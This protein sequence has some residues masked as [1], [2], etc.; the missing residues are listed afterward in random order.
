MTQAEDHAVIGITAFTLA[1][2]VCGLAPSLEVLNI[3][4]AMQGVAAATVDV[5]SLAL[6]SEAFPDPKQ[7][8]RA[9][10]IWTAIANVGTALGS[11]LGGVLFEQFG[12]RASSSSTCRWAYR[13]S[14]FRCATSPSR[15]TSGRNSWICRGRRCSW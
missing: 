9:I 2:I 10:G 7:K 15:A 14:I 4:R 13:S 1:S 3:A 6:V 12:W 5:T 8:A 11:T